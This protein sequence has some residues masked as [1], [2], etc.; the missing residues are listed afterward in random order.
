M[1]KVMI[2]TLVMRILRSKRS[3]C[4]YF[5]KYYHHLVEEVWYGTLRYDIHVGTREQ[6]YRGSESTSKSGFEEPND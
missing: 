1:L 6:V 5:N 2:I 4:V 3:V